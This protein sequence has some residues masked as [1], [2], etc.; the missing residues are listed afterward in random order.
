MKKT[1]INV[2]W[3]EIYKTTILTAWLGG[4]G[5]L[6]Y[7]IYNNPILLLNPENFWSN[8]IAIIG[9]V[10]A[11]LIGWQIYSAI[12]WNSKAERISKIE[13]GY[14]SM[15]AALNNTRNFSKASML[16]ME[17]Q[18]LIDDA[19]KNEN[20]KKEDWSVTD[21][22]D[23]YL[24]LLEAVSLYTSPSVEKPIENCIKQMY[25]M[26]E[27]MRRHGI[28]VDVDFQSNCDELFEHI[29]KN[30]QHLTIAQYDK[31]KDLKSRRVNLCNPN[32][33]ANERR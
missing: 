6:M 11:T 28:G 5:Y 22:S 27:A 8:I 1:R 17:A 26:I 14:R 33:T 21:F 30:K 24:M 20:E 23:A 2:K 12:D 29:K 31:L 9:I 18:S 3:G 32:S 4:S 10:V 16:Y 15:F 7:R 19:Y 13:D 25:A